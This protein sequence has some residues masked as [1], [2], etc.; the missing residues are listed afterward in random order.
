VAPERY[1]TPPGA[2]ARSTLAVA[3]SPRPS[4]P[5]SL[6]PQVMTVPS[7]SAA[8]LWLAAAANEM[9]LARES[10]VSERTTMV[11]R[12]EGPLVVPS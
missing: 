2:W 11:G 6:P 7:A 4:W 10:D 1:E 12:V 8:V 3:E 5:E 9:T